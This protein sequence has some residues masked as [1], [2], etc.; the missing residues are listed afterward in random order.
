MIPF[1]FVL[2][3][4]AVSSQAAAP[5]PVAPAHSADGE[6]K[7]IVVV[8]RRVEDSARALAACIARQ[9]PPK[10]EIDASLAY[11]EDQFLAGDYPEAQRT[12][13]KARG[14]NMRYKRELP[15]EV[16]DLLRAS[17]RMLA[18]NGQRDAARIT[19]ID[20]LDALKSGLPSTDRRIFIQR[21][22]VGDA[23]AKEGRFI[24]ARDVYNKVANQAAA[25]G[26]VRVKGYALFR[27]AGLYTSIAPLVPAY[28]QTAFDSLRRIDET[29]E[30]DLAPF[31]DAAKF[32]RCRLQGTGVN[33][34]RDCIAATNTDRVSKAELIYAPP[35]DLNNWRQENPSTVARLH[36]EATP[37]W[38]DVAF[39][40]A[41][42]GTV[43][44]IDT[45]R[46]S[47]NVDAGW[48]KLVTD[49]LGERRYRP[50]QR[51]PSDEGLRRIER[52]SIVYDVVSMKGTR[53]RAR[54]SVPHI[55]IL[56]LTVEPGMS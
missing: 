25:A 4:A 37:Q 15:V 42:D 21:L 52:Y 6:G 30:P 31:R 48:M 5:A 2:L 3:Q 51:A 27:I 55:E 18:V 47:T 22:A 34:G 14:R 45:V 40:V 41:P 39:R 9:C 54:S 28:R 24:A 20:S 19:A 36:G 1:A 46:T 26:D 56:D 43:R 32:L 13:A 33:A 10:E 49:A 7:T 35:I 44:D 23:F 16:G 29:T 53:I 50:L 17:G 12:L 8:G 38:A 11:A